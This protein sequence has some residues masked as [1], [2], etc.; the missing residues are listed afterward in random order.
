MI[1]G[2]AGVLLWLFWFLGAVLPVESAGAEGAIDILRHDLSLTIRPSSHVAEAVDRLTVEIPHPGRYVLRLGADFVIQK[3]FLDGKKISFEEIDE[4]ALLAHYQAAGIDEEDA[5]RAIGVSFH[6]GGDPKHV[7]EVRYRGIVYDTLKVPEYSRGTLAEETTGIIGEEGVFLSPETRWYPDNP[8]DYAFFSIK[9][10]SPP[11]FESVTEG[12]LVARSVSEASIDTEWDVSYP[13]KGVY[14]VAGNY[15]IKEFEA[16]GVKIMGYFFPSEENLIDQYLEASARYITLYNRIIGPYPFSKFAVVENFFPTGYGMPSYTLLG[17]RV[18]RLPFIVRTSLGHEVAHNWWGNCVYV[19]YDKGNWCEGL[20]VY[21]A[22]YRY[23]EAISDSAAVS[24][25]SSQNIDYTSYVSEENDFPLSVFHERT[26]PASRAIG[27]GKSAMVFHML[28]RLVGEETYYRALRTFYQDFRFQEASWDDIQRTFER[29]SGRDLAS[30]F[31]QWVR[32]KGAPTVSIGTANLEEMPDWH[33]RIHL[34]LEQDPVYELLVPVAIIGED[35]TFQTDV[36]LSSMIDSFTFD[37][38][39]RPT[40]IAADPSHD[41]FR[42]LEPLEIPPTIS[43]AL[44]DKEAVIALPSQAGE[45]KR[46]A[47]EALA[48]QLGRTGEGRVVQDIEV[49]EADVRAG[50]VIVLGNPEE[51]AVHS[52]FEVPPD[53]A[54]APD[55]F[56]VGGVEYAGPGHSAFVTFRNP[57]NVASCVCVVIGNSAESIKKSGY[58]IIHYGKYSYVTFLD[59]N[60]QQAGVF[61]IEKNPLLYSFSSPHK[62]SRSH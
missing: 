16:E 60:R 40:A 52:L 26:T 35:T 12:R 45:E 18:I 15:I 56:S 32:R 59:G 62:A 39:F 19:D 43:W 4:A 34:V 9:V 14:L 47:F 57:F 27:Y 8:G 37:V 28:K 17:R 25:R 33:F 53:I 2:R 20:T 23:K 42:R 22:D 11:G 29:V 10:S 58:K 6:I 41:V 3:L 49:S 1:G 54:L 46:A 13:T 61:P 24:Y 50:A 31:D 51:N 44:G 5:K 38:D 21:F 30:F 36:T 48:D 55:H 7:V